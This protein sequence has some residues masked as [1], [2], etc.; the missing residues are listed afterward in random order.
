MWEMAK[1]TDAFKAAVAGATTYER[2]I[3]RLFGIPESEI[4]S[5]LREAQAG[6]VSLDRLEVTTCLRRGE[7]EVSTRYEPPAQQDY[8]T[9]I[10]FIRDRHPDTLFSEDGATIDEQ[11]VALLEGRTIATAESC[12]GGLLAARL[13]DRPGSSAYFAGSVIVYSN[14][15]KA[16][17]AGVDPELIARFGAVS[18]EVARA[19]ALGATE[20]FDAEIGVGITGIAGPDG[21]TEEKPVGTVCFSVI[22]QGG[23]EITRRTRLP[24]GRSDVRERSTTVAMHLVRRLLIG[25][26]DGQLPGAGD[27]R[28]VSTGQG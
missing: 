21:G 8:E 9:L 5:T 7:I 15:A 6:G 1:E 19:L 10:E 27:R 20:R 3:V 4:A 12:T 2:G 16:A 17:L 25:Q 13:T 22:A 14:Q 23:A 26:T 18:N 24:G 28:G 11:V